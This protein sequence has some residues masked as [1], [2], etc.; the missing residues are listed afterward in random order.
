M[1][2]GVCAL[3]WLGFTVGCSGDVENGGSTS[4][5][6]CTRLLTLSCQRSTECGTLFTQTHFADVSSCVAAI[7]SLC[8]A[9]ATLP[10]SGPLVTDYDACEPA[11]R[12]ASCDSLQ[13]GNLPAACE[14]KP[15]TLADGSS[16][17][18]SSQC[19]SS[20]CKID[21]AADSDCGVCS[22]R[23]RVGG[24]C[25]GSSQCEDGL[26]CAFGSATPT[27]ALPQAADQ[28]CDTA[29]PCQNTL[30]CLDGACAAPLGAGAACTGAVDCDVRLGLWCTAGTCQPISLADPGQSCDSAGTWCRAPGSCSK[31]SAADARTCV[32]R[33]PNG[34][35]C[36]DSTECTVASVCSDGVCTV[37]QY[38]TCQ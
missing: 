11:Y 17:A 9:A 20:Y 25:Q 5:D 23:S 18:A 29:H 27:C 14:P 2:Y 15:G 16:C 4:A 21:Y 34:A 32:A 37:F 13:S 28:N 31:A 36:E 19:Q 12:A 24:S 10:G 7:G 22:T 30:R 1:R 6:A 3:V 33:K 26:V 38:P 8:T 35:A